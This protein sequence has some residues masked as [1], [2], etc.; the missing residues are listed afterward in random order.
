MIMMGFFISPPDSSTYLYINFIGSFWFLHQEVAHTLILKAR[1][2]P[3]VKRPPKGPKT[4]AKRDMDI[5]GS[6][7]LYFEGSFE[8]TGEETSEGADYGGKRNLI[9]EG[10]TYLYFEGSLEAAGE[11]SSE[12]ADD[13]GE[14]GHGY[15]GQHL[16]LFWR[17]TWSHWRRILRRV[18][19]RR[20][21]G[22]WI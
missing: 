21:K 12:G 6:T 17:L 5:E 10:S 1:L 9:I 3:L 22:T 15:R 2:K 8:A 19:L 7:Y 11:E 18:R 20:R 14:E 13:G 16:P 4:E